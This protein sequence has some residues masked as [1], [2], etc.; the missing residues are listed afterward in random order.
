[1]KRLIY[2]ISALLITK[3]VATAQLFGA[4]ATFPN[5]LYAK[6]FSE[7]E[8]IK[9]VKVSYQSIGSG[10]GIKMLISPLPMFY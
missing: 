3:T 6:M 5:P 8:K 7:Y 4:G 2:V 1:M 9:G 10:G